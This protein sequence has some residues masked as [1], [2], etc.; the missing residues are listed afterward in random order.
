MPILIPSVFH[1][2]LSI[3]VMHPILSFFEA[4]QIKAEFVRLFVDQCE[5]CMSSYFQYSFPHTLLDHAYVYFA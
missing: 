4:N 2:D 1:P 5:A 3:S